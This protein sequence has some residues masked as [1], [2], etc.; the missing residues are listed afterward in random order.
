MGRWHIICLLHAEIH[1]RMGSGSQFARNRWETCLWTRWQALKTQDQNVWCHICRWLTSIIILCIWTT[2]RSIQ[3]HDCSSNRMGARQGSKTEYTVSEV[4]VW[5]IY[6]ILFFLLLPF[7]VLISSIACEFNPV[8]SLSFL[9]HF[10]Q[11]NHFSSL[12]HCYS[13][14]V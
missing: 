7:V 11:F 9:C 6:Q 14:Y 5:T 8:V 1:V 10:S 4:P 2:S 3:R 13:R 12:R